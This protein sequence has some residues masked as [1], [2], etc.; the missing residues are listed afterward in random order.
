MENNKSITIG[1]VLEKIEGYYGVI[2]HN[3]E[4]GSKYRSAFD[5]DGFTEAELN[6]EFRYFEVS[7]IQG[8]M[9]IEFTV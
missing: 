6:S 9:W 7:I 5:M 8:K 4:Y 3:G 2:I 1:Q